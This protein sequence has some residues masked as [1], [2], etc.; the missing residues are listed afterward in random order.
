MK[1][2]FLKKRN[3]LLTTATFSWGAYALALVALIVLV[4]L[5]A[6]NAFL[7]AVTPLFKSADALAAVNHAFFAHFNDAAALT[8]SYEKSQSDNEALVIENESLREKIRNIEDLFPGGAETRPQS[9]IVAGVVAR[10][11][12]SPYDTLLIAA[13]AKSGIARGM[14]VFGA[15]GTPLGIVSEVVDDF[16]WVNLFTRPGMQTQAVVSSAHTEITLLG[17][18]SGTFKVSLSRA[19]TITEGDSVYVPGP[20]FLPVGKVVRIDGNPSSPSVDLRIVPLVNPRSVSWVVVRDVGSSVRAKFE[21][22]SSTPL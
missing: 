10:P 15:G 3:A 9:G 11:L 7:F 16:S 1:K 4:R 19:A 2:I 22:A 6:P 8:R 14:E 5:L 21:Q 13:G 12:E 20:G 17:A 18:G